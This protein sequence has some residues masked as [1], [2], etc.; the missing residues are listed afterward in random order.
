MLCDSTSTLRD[1]SLVVDLRL[2]PADQIQ[3]LIAESPVGWGQ[4][5]TFDRRDL[6]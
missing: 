1:D 2:N 5:R 6:E 3:G 4:L